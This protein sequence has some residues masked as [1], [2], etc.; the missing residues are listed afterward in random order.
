MQHTITQGSKIQGNA[1]HNR[2]THGKED[3]TRLE[4]PGWDNTTQYT[5]YTRKN[6]TRRYMTTQEKKRKNKTR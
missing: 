5:Q 3:T 6:N 4:K 2:I 1:R